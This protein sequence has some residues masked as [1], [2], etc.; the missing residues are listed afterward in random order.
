MRRSVCS[1]VGFSFVWESIGWVKVEFRSFSVSSWVVSGGRFQFG[2]FMLDFSIQKENLD[3]ERIDDWLFQKVS[4]RRQYFRVRGTGLQFSIS[5]L[6]SDWLTFCEHN[7]TPTIG[8][9]FEG[10]ICKTW[11]NWLADRVNFLSP[12]TGKGLEEGEKE[13]R[14]EKI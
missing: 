11:F 6:V 10:Q 7:S 1:A 2:I 3:W 13:N 9:K 5:I 4:S 14:C 12:L 8:E